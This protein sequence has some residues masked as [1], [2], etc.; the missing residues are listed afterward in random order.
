MLSSGCLTSKLRRMPDIQ[1]FQL[2]KP[3][4]K[5]AFGK[6]YVAR[7]KTTMDLYAIKVIRK[8]DM[9]KK[10]MVDAVLTE[11]FA[12]SI[13]DNPYVVKL[14]YSFQN[15]KYLF[16]VMEFLVGGD[17][18]SLL[19]VLGSLDEGLAAFYA[20]EIALALEY[21]HGHN[22][23]HRDLKPDNMLITSKG[24]LKLT[25][26]GLS[27]VNVR[28]Q[29]IQP[30]S[31]NV[32]EKSTPFKNA[33]IPLRVQSDLEAKTSKKG[34][35]LLLLF[36]KKSKVSSREPNNSHRG[37]RI[38][39]EDRIDM[40]GNWH[41]C[42]PDECRGASARVT[43]IP[44]TPDYLAPELLLGQA[45]GFEVDW[46]AFGVCVYEM[47]MGAPPFHGESVQKIFQRILKGELDVPCL[48]EDCSFEAWDLIK[49]CL[50]YAPSKRY[51]IVKIKGHEWF[52]KNDINW[53]TILKQNGPWVPN[54]VNTEDTSF[55]PVIT[56]TV[57]LFLLAD[58]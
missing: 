14:Y 48:G 10:N 30:F 24:H 57:R 53:S 56:N 43:K 41:R 39:S 50:A 5:G 55:L 1:D 51:G 6:V 58:C 17:L 33:Q 19:Y 49:G 15:A 22:I 3:I 8:S 29:D 31:R 47:I 9:I 21:L 13:L 20:A 4:S 44:G 45:H 46:W 7:K 40:E 42:K 28:E 18:A 27:R 52:A 11:K 54:P 25:D 23:I 34:S 37:A 26:F 2:L 12:L 16:L 36:P 35:F 32:G 38:P